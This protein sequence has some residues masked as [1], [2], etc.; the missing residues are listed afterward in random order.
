MHRRGNAGRTIRNERG[1][2]AVEYTPLLAIIALAIFF[3][4]SILGPWVREHIAEPA[5]HLH[6]C[7]GPYKLFD[8]HTEYTGISMPAGTDR[9]LNGDGYLCIEVIPGNGRG[10]TGDRYNIKDNNR[11]PDA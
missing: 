9:D 10:N 4:V 8:T 1:A 2:A 3:S 7:P 11:P 5:V 6:R